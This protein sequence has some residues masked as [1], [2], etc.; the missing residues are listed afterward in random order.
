M[1]IKK[2][3]ID[4]LSKTKITT[5]LSSLI[6]CIGITSLILNKGPNLSIDFTGGTIAQIIFSKDITINEI[7]ERLKKTALDDCEIIEFGK[8]MNLE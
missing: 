6:I 1:L 4:F 8:K 5:V 3:K 7:R 2:T